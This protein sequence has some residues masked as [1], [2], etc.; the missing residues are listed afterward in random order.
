[1]SL[2]DYIPLI[3]SSALAVCVIAF[4]PSITGLAYQDGRAKALE[5][6]RVRAIK[7]YEDPF[8]REMREYTSRWNDYSSQLEALREESIGD[9]RESVDGLNNTS[10]NLN[11]ASS[12]T[13]KISEDLAE[14]IR[15]FKISEEEKDE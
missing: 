2:K 10:K 9:L 6:Q 4:F 7:I 8:V 11:S 15:Q 3:G 1:M 14:I 12:S 5:E 13:N